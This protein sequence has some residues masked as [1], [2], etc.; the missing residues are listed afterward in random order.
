MQYRASVSPFLI[1]ISFPV[2]PDSC[3]SRARIMDHVANTNF[4]LSKASE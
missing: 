4:Q 2:S 1:L 3:A